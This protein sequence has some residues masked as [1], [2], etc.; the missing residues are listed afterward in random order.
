M[1]SLVTLA[2]IALLAGCATH[3][4][5]EKQ[6]LDEAS[7]AYV[8][9]LPPGPAQLRLRATKIPSHGFIA[10]NLAIAV[11]GGA[12]ATLLREELQDAKK[13]G[14]NFFLIMGSSTGVDVAVIGNA[15]EGLDLKGMQIYYSGT[16]A[17]KDKV[18]A[19]VEKTQAQF[20]YISAQ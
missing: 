4:K 8:A 19:A 2:F 6:I 12:N 3:G 16:Q 15:V 17:Q 10:D 13:L 7:T 5:S 18:Q 14:D 1:K 9:S 11:G 20:N